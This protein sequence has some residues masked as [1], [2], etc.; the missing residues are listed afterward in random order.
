[1]DASKN[2]NKYGY[3]VVMNINKVIYV[4]SEKTYRSNSFLPYITKR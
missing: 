3:F 1:M 4:V 2:Y